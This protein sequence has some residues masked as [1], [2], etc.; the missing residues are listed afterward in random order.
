[1]QNNELQNYVYP[2]KSIVPGHLKLERDFFQNVNFNSYCF[3]FRRH[4]KGRNKDKIL[5]GSVTQL[6]NTINIISRSELKSE[7]YSDNILTTFICILYHP[8]QH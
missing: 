5:T 6:S 2:E 7:L 8:R 4:R 1:M 3:C